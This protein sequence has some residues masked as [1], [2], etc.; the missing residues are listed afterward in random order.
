MIASRLITA[1]S[2]VTPIC[3]ALSSEW[4]PQQGDSSAT[5]RHVGQVINFV[6]S[7]GGRIS[8]YRVTAV[9]RDG[10]ANYVTVWP[11]L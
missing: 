4:P 6:D 1:N 9:H 10:A 7:A 5:G 2:P 11:R 3:A 8:N